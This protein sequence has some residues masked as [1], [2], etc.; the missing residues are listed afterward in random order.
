MVMEPPPA[1]PT[2]KL[3]PAAPTAPAAAAATVEKEA[4][5]VKPTVSLGRNLHFKENVQP[6]PPPTLEHYF[7]DR[8]PTDSSEFGDG[9]RTGRIFTVDVLD[10]GT[11]LV[12]SDVGGYVAYS[13]GGADCG[14]P[15]DVDD[16]DASPAAEAR[17][18]PRIRVPLI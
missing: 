10:A 14:F 7:L 8:V 12:D 9:L 13:S 1:A 5:L 4:V 18:A 15:A 3:K 16:D 17:P 6:A 2:P 11:N